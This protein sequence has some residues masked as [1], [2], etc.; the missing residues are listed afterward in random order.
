VTTAPLAFGP[1]ELHIDRRLLSRD[2]VPVSVGARALDLLCALAQHRDRIVDKDELMELAWPGMVVEENNLAVQIG[3]LRKLLGAQAIATVRGRGYRFVAATL[4]V[5]AAAPCPWT[6]P[7]GRRR[8]NLPA[9]LPPLIGRATECATLAGWIA[10]ARLVTVTGAGGI[11]KS[12]LAQAVAHGLVD[13]WPD[14]VWMVEL[15]GLGDPA[16]LANAVAQ[17]LGIALQDRDGADAALAAE[18]APREMLLVLDNCEHLLDATAALTEHLLAS[19][20]RLRVLATS[21]E[22][23]RLA[24]EQQY[25]IDPLSVPA[26]ASAPG[27]RDYGALALFAARVCA[28]D[29]AF[30]LD[31]HRLAQAIGLCRSLDGLPLAIELAAARVPLLG[32]R[33]VHDRLD[34]R[35]RLLTGG[36]RTALPRHQTLRAAM[37]WSHGL[38]TDPQRAVFHRLGVFCGGF[39]MA[40]AQSLCAD[41]ATAPWQVLEHVGALVDKSLVIVGAADPPRYR[42]LESARAF[43]LEQLAAA[44]DAAATHAGHARTMAAFLREVDDANLDGE[45]RTD[46]YAALVLPELDNLR[47]AYAWAGTPDGD[48]SVAIAIAATATPLSD[49]ASEFRDWLLDQWP[50]AAGAVLDPAIEARL[51][52]GLA[53]FN[54]TGFVPTHEAHAAAMRAATLYRSLGLTRR[55]VSSLRLAATWLIVLGDHA[56]AAAALD[57]ADALIQPDWGAEFRLTLLRSRTRLA[58]ET[59]QLDRALQTAREEITLARRSRD[60]RLEVIARTNHGEVLW[61]AGEIAQAS[62]LLEALR[63]EIGT[64]PVTDYELLDVLQLQSALASEHGHAGH[65]LKFARAALPAMRSTRRFNLPLLAHLLLRLDRC[66]A[67]ARLVGAFDA[68]NRAGLEI[69]GPSEARLLA[70]TRAGL[71]ERLAPP[72]LA[73]LHRVGAGLDSAAIQALLAE[74]L[75]E[76]QT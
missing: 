64:H 21:Q 29:P 69:V 39:T 4:A 59:G 20:P 32:L 73:T 71:A 44:G 9:M 56:G 24:Q 74:S 57:E 1:F 27:A 62:A 40:L 2:G 14:G 38:L 58:S 61:Q 49:Y 76:Q 8:T 35:L 22:P 10:N 51:A 6:P 19:A 75:G 31:D 68:R 5:D 33:T 34:E 65:A 55:M 17:Q 16:L 60:W 23:L 12:R 46:A 70:A 7:A 25:R 54:M 3:S 72:S 66:D 18:L 41:A 52:R 26:D 53:A 36:H 43:A 28:I 15:A 11:G 30:V 45:L 50:L 42:L 37:A 48:R 13:D 63:V 47:A 67:A